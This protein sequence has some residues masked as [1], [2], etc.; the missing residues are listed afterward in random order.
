MVHSQCKH[1]NICASIIC[2]GLY[3]YLRKKNKSFA[4]CYQFKCSRC[5]HLSVARLI[6]HSAFS[7]RTAVTMTNKK[8]LPEAEINTIASA[9]LRSDTNGS[10]K[11]LTSPRTTKNKRILANLGAWRYGKCISRGQKE[12]SYI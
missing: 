3:S 11:E 1:A 10:A 6:E 9:R 4:G 5:T 8:E 12:H 2:A 7:T